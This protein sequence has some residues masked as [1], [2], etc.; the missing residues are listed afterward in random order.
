MQLYFGTGG[1]ADPNPSSLE[2][3]VSNDGTRFETLVSLS[4]MPLVMGSSGPEAALDN[5]IYSGKMA[6]EA[7]SESTTKGVRRI[8]VKVE[9]PYASV[10]RCAC[11]QTSATTTDTTGYSI[12]GARSGDTLSA[13]IVFTLPRGMGEDLQMTG[14]TQSAALNQIVLIQNLLASILRQNGEQLLN[15]D[16]SVQEGTA[17][18]TSPY[19]AASLQLALTASD[20]KVG[21][22]ILCNIC[23]NDVTTTKGP[24]GVASALPDV[25][26]IIQRGAALLKPILA[27]GRYGVGSN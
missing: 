2:I 13:H 22:N 4:A 23:N 25:T 11:G 14:A 18:K 1:S 19:G 21:G 27:G 5:C 20:A 16:A 6:V 17:A 15:S 24:D 9:L 12:D 3:P 8:L 7:R 26:S 10:S